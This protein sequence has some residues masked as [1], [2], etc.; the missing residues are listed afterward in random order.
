VKPRPPK[1]RFPFDRQAVA[2]GSFRERGL[3]HQRCLFVPCWMLS[4]VKGSRVSF[5]F[6]SD[7]SAGLVEACCMIAADSWAFLSGIALLFVFA[8][9]LFWEKNLFGSLKKG[10]SQRF[11]SRSQ[12]VGEARSK[13]C[14]GFGSL[15]ILDTHAL[16]RRLPVHRWRGG[17]EW[18]I[19]L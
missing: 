13:T 18:N 15:W 19:G 7:R 4:F 3:K 11:R 2:R 9:I 12:R 16:K 10:F 5:G 8:I 6:V 1:K 14:F 17:A